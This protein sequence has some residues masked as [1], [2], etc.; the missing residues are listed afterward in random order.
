MLRSHNKSQIGLVTAV[1]RRNDGGLAAKHN[2]SHCTGQ[3]QYILSK[4]LICKSAN[5][6]DCIGKYK[7]SIGLIVQR[8]V[9]SI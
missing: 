8:C 7:Q 5:P 4:A 9:Y 2:E 6:Q 3:D 1:G